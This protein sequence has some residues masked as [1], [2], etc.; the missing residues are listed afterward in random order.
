MCTIIITTIQLLGCGVPDSK[1]IRDI[2]TMEGYHA[3]EEPDLNQE[4]L[5]ETMTDHHQYEQD[6][7]AGDILQEDKPLGCIRMY[8]ININGIK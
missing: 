2:S 6:Y 7:H 5:Q 3:P 4:D 1:R 8:C